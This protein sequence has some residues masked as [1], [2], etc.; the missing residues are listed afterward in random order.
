M[1]LSDENKKRILKFLG[2]ALL[3]FGFSVSFSEFFSCMSAE[4]R[5][6]TEQCLEALQGKGSSIFGTVTIAAPSEAAVATCMKPAGEQARKELIDHYS[7]KTVLIKGKP[8]KID[9]P[10]CDKETKTNCTL[11]LKQK[12]FFVLHGIPQKTDWSSAN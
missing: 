8:V 6:P 5:T 2:F 3:A 1:T 10:E 9:L 11:S 12:I 7:S 4:K